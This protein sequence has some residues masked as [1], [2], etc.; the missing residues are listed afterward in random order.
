M[1]YVCVY[2]NSMTYCT[3]TVTTVHIV[4]EQ[5]YG[6]YGFPSSSIFLL[7]D[8]FMHRYGQEQAFIYNAYIH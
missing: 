3:V 4:Q 7:I 5:T 1:F 2:Y 6:P 8:I